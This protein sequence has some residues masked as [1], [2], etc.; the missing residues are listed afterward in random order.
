MLSSERLRQD[1]RNH[2]VP[3]LD[4]FPDDQDPSILYMVMP[5]LRSIVDPAFDLVEEFIDFIDQILEVSIIVAFPK[6]DKPL[7]RCR[8]LYSCTNKEWRMGR[9]AIPPLCWS[10]SLDQQLHVREHHDGWLCNV[11]AWVPSRQHILPTRRKDDGLATTTE[12]GACEVLLRRL[13]PVYVFSS[14]HLSETRHRGRW[15]GSGS[16][17]ALKRRTVRSFQGGHLPR[18]Q[19]FPPHVLQGR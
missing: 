2:C 1:N 10:L 11:S 8:V 14:R 3:I 7:S 13:Q 6:G 5:F 17:G 9:H 19:P 16:T 4:V 18:G 12:C 15:Q